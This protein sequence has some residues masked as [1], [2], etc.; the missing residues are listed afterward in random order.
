MWDHT[1]FPT[2]HFDVIWASPCCSQYSCARRNAKTPRDLN[3]ADALAKRPLELATYFQPPIWLLENPETGLLKTRTFMSGLPWSDVDYCAYSSWGYRK[4]TRLW[5]NCGFV[6]KLCQGSGRCP[7]MEG[8][9]H[10][11]S[12]QQG[13][14]R[15]STGLHGEHHSTKQLYKL[16]PV[17][18]AEIEFY[19]REQLPNPPLWE[20]Y[21]D[22]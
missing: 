11:T 8:H 20:Q 16:P 14:N 15:T 22:Q 10:K 5:N 7:N 1:V 19:C 2:G 9:R 17:L 3:H 6:G 12:A 21:G 18:C 4:R 13:R